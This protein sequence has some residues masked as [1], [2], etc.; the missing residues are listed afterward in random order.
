MKT[1]LVDAING[2]VLEDGTVF[3]QMYELLESY[4]NRKIVL[5]GA[6]D[7]QIK[8]FGLDKLPYEL[9]TQKHEPEKTDPTYFK[10]L[11]AKYALSPDEVV[12]FEHNLE[13]AESARSVGIKTCF[14]D[15]I[16]QDIKALKEF[17][18]KNLES[19]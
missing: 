10:T 13:A 5:T 19:D 4:P 2:F 8:H 17:I 7:E 18:D 1:I 12:Y 16:A 15:H 3:E 9:F 6:N 14:Y 11:L